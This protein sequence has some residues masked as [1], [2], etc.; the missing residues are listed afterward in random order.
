MRIFGPLSEENGSIYRGGSGSLLSLLSIF[1]LQI[2][3]L[4]APPGGKKQTTGE[5]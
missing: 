4:H 3:N 1:D 5:F 2:I